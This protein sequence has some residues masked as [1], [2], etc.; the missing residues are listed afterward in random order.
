V[1]QGGYLYSWSN[2]KDTCYGILHD[3]GT[4]IFFSSAERVW[5]SRE[6][7]RR[8]VTYFHMHFVEGRSQ[9]GMDAHRVKVVIQL[10]NYSLSDLGHHLPNLADFQDVI[11]LLCLLNVATL[12]HLIYLPFYE[13]KVGLFDSGHQSLFSVTRQ[14][15][16]AILGYMDRNVLLKKDGVE[17]EFNP[18]FRTYFVQQVR[19]LICQC[20]TRQPGNRSIF[21][22]EKP[23]FQKLT[24]AVAASFH[25]KGWFVKEIKRQRKINYPDTSYEWLSD[26]VFVTSLVRNAAASGYSKGLVGFPL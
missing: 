18:F 26:E 13:E 15:A 5:D 4:G 24:E 12:G 19:S 10:K 14:K 8:I 22:G 23:I 9:S 20:S 11:S 2:I 7:I 17:V 21:Q 25:A 16:E 6:L 1:S 3:F